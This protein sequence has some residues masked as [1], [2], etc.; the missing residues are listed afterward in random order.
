MG[1]VMENVAGR[2]KDMESEEG[3]VSRCAVSQEAGVE[4]LTRSTN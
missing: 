1:N 3:K 4:S 2:R